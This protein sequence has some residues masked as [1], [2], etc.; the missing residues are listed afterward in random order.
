MNRVGL[1][2]GSFNPIHQGHLIL[3]QYMLQN[4][5]LDEVWYVLTPQNPLKESTDMAPT[6]HRLAMLNAALEGSVSLKVCDAELSLPQPNYT[7]DTLRLLSAQNPQTHFS[8]IMGADNIVSIERWREYETI[9][10]NF[11]ILVY[12]RLG[13]QPKINPHPNIT[14]TL[15]PI[16][17]ISSTNIRKWVREGKNVDYFT[18]R[19]VAQ[20]IETQQLYK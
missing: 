17:E 5:N 12:P 9:I 15:A 6:P 4:H 19:V 18:P 7:I 3:G 1:L 14:I 20:Y 8:I 16:V 13:F 2:F 10:A 11:S